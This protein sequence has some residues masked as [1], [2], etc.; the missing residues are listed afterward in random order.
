MNKSLVFIWL[1]ITSLALTAPGWAEDIYVAETAAGGNTGADCANAKAMSWLN[2]ASNWGAGAD[3]VSAGDTVH[4]CGT[5]TSSLNIA[6]SGSSGLPITILFEGGAKFSKA[7]WGTGANGAIHG[8]G[9][10]WITID[11]GT[12]GIVENTANGT[13]L[14]N[15]QSSKPL[16]FD[17]CNNITIRNLTVQ[18]IYLRTYNSTDFAGISTSLSALDC[19]NFTVHDC[20]FTHSHNMLYFARI[21]AGISSNWNLYNNTLNYSSGPVIFGTGANNAIIDTVNF[22]NNTVNMGNQFSFPGGEHWHGDSI[23]IWA[24]QSGAQV[25]NVKIYGNTFGP[26]HPMK[27]AEGNSANT[28]IIYVE[29]ATHNVWI[30]NNLFLSDPGYWS[31]DGAVVFNNKGAGATGGKLY[32]NTFI[33]K[34]GGN[35]MGFDTFPTIEMKN[36]I[37]IGARMGMVLFGSA[38]TNKNQIDYNVYYGIGMQWGDFYNWTSWRAKGYDTHSYNANP[39]LDSNYVPRSGDTVA[40]DKGVSLSSYFTTDKAGTTRPQGSAWDIGA[41]ERAE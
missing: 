5:L 30:Y 33:L 20:T 6:G 23:H 15:H 9:K 41:Y 17:S 7:Y 32:N 24:D 3:K 36:N 16:N 8:S 28:A 18:N 22:Y 37:M 39:F 27:V 1:C 4:L 19:N 29:T 31:T 34:G 2:N 25:N 12:N 21:S 10:S 11:G 26:Q 13:A 38:P 35:G 40:K 14:E